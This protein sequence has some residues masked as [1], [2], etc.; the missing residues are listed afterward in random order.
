MKVYK[1]RGLRMHGR[2]SSEVP[3]P[4]TRSDHMDSRLGAG[5]GGTIKSKREG[6]R[7]LMNE[8]EGVYHR[9]SRPGG[10]ERE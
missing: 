6:L 7:D 3:R 10:R 8:L 1:G 2:A 4:G 9:R 5:N